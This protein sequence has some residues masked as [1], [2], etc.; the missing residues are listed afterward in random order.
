MAV[1][2]HDQRD[3]EFATEFGLP[4]VEVIAGGDISQAAYNGDGEVVNSDYLNGLSVESAKEAITA[5][6]V[7]DG[8]GQARVEYKLRDWLFARQRYWGEPFPIVYDEAGRAYPLPESELPVELPDIPDYAPVHVRSRRRRQRA[9]AAAEQG[10]R[11]GARGA[12]PRRRPQDLHPRHQRHA[13]VGGQLVVR[14]ALHRS[15]QLGSVVRQGERGVLDGAATGGARPRRPRRR[16]H[17]RRRR[18]TCGAASAVFA[19]SGTRCSTT[20][21]MY[22]RG[23]RTGGWS[24]RA[25]SRRTPTPTRAGTYVPAAEVVERDG[26]FYWPGPTAKSR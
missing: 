12:G 17:V 16:R 21:A 5:R 23:S 1:P 22:R 3:W 25:T 20:W 4:I 15:A 18:R 26:K 9:V 24:T 11:L 2:G 10:D 8:V 6:L 14:A 13:A 7:A 19:G